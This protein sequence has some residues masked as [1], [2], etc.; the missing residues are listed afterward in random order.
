MN[1]P[2]YIVT[3]VFTEKVGK[4]AQDMGI[5]IHSHYGYVTDFNMTLQQYTKSPKMHGKKFPAVWLVEPFALRTERGGVYAS[6]PELR[7]FILMSSD[8]NYK[9]TER[10]EKVYKTALYPILNKLLDQFCTYPF[11][12]YRMNLKATITDRYYWGESQQ[13]VINDVVD[14]IELKLH[15]LKIHSNQNC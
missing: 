10:K 6:I 4:V 15:N 5:N 7:V 2:P 14:T 13:N 11:M 12:G 8:K 1:N 3:D 9:A